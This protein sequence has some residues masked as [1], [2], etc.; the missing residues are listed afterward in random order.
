MSK[1]FSSTVAGASILITTIGLLSKGFGFFREVVYANSFGLQTNFDIY[2]IGAVLPII[3]NT[4][5]FFLAQNFFIPSYHNKLADSKGKADNFFYNSFWIFSISSLLLSLILFLISPYLISAYLSGNNTAF[6]KVALNVFQIFLITIPFNAGFSI[7]ASYFQAEFNFKTPAIS[8]LFQNIIIISLVLTLTNSIGIYTIPLGYLLGTIVQF[9]FLLIE[10]KKRHRNVFKPIKLNFKELGFAN[11]VLLITIIIEVVNQLYVF[12]DRYFYGSVDPGGIAALNYATVLFTLPISIFSL[13]ISTAIF[14]KISQT[15]YSKDFSNLQTQI[16]YGIKI[17]IFLF[18]PIT[19]IFVLFGNSILRIFYERGNF[20]FQDTEM[21]FQILRILA[22]SLIFYSS[23]AIINKV[24]YSA[25][26]VKNLLFLSV[27]I[28]MFKIVLNFIL[29]QN[30]KQNGL[31]FSTAACYILLSTGGI[32][33]VFKK[34]KLQ[35]NPSYI[36]VLIFYLING[37]IAYTILIILKPHIELSPIL[38]SVVNILIFCIIYLIGLVIIQPEEYLVFKD[39][40]IK[41]FNK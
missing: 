22:F 26:L 19:I 30:F 23:Y 37:A 17:N 25:G 32:F 18:V 29:V 14:P 20:S 6:Y 38:N 5:I 12:I 34:L 8:T 11:K 35:K 15:F 21:T 27:I 41:A 13:A 16:F 33:L 36:Y 1:K 7:L 3:V 9:L 39:S 4:S 31:A 28:F 2:L 24:I 10:I 40:L